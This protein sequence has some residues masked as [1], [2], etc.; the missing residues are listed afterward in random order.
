[1]VPQELQLTPSLGEARQTLERKR[2]SRDRVAIRDCARSDAV[3]AT[4]RGATVAQPQG[5][6][7]AVAGAKQASGNQR[8]QSQARRDSHTQWCSGEAPVQMSA[9]RQMH[10]R[11]ERPVATTDES[12][13]W[14]R[15]EASFRTAIARFSSQPLAIERKARALPRRSDPPYSLPRL[16][17]PPARI[18]TSPAKER[19]SP[20]GVH[21]TRC[22]IANYRSIF[23]ESARAGV[24]RRRQ[25]QDEHSR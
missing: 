5:G 15:H 9:L 13:S 4:D 3:S 8:P 25:S 14:R 6:N 22:R 10:N 7:I 12:A 11:L 20:E 23:P 24:R 19:T 1:M 18:I 21:S 16:P 17:R 2:V